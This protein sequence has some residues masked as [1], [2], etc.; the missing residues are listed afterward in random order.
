MSIQSYVAELE[1]FIAGYR[2]SERT[3]FNIITAITERLLQDRDLTS[4][5]RSQS[6]ELYMGEINSIETDKGDKGK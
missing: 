5:E 3:K 4:K 1:Q 6:F 2:A